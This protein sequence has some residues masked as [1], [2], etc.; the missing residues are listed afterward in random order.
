VHY[1]AYG[2][3]IVLGYQIDKDNFAHILRT[4]GNCWK[5]NELVDKKT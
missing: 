5:N 2:A 3:C 1:A 4:F